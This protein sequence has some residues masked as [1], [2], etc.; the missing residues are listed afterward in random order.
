MRKYSII[1]IFI[2][3]HTKILVHNCS[4]F[5]DYDKNSLEEY[6][7]RLPFRAKIPKLSF[8]GR[9]KILYITVNGLSMRIFE[10]KICWEDTGVLKISFTHFRNP[11]KNRWFS[12]CTI[13]CL[14]TQFEKGEQKWF[15]LNILIS[16]QE[17][18]LKENTVKLKVL[19]F[20]LN[21]HDLWEG[22]RIY[23][24]S[25]GWEKLVSSTWAKGTQIQTNT[26]TNI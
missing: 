11:Q 5:F 13:P 18:G 7:F 21:S 8:L 10:Q 12:R 4:G 25:T 14:S 15:T 24:V 23:T 6:F 3:T 20:Y 2:Q 1:K 16:F 17:N 26:Q 22:K 19:M 9:Q